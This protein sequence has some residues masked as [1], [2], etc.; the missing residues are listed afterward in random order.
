MALRAVFIG[1]NQYNDQG[2]SELNGAKRDALALW[3]LFTDSIEGLTSKLLVDQDATNS[4]VRKYVFGAL[5]E[6]NGDDVII[7]SFAGHGS[8][9]GNIILYDTEIGNLPGTAISMAS[10]AE[11]FK[12]TKA[13]TVLF[14]LDCCFS[15]QTPARVLETAGLPRSSFI[16]NEVYGEG[17]IILSACSVSES[18]WEQPG[19][20][21]GLLTYAIITALTDSDKQIVN[22]PDVVGEIIRLTRIEA[23]RINVK[24]T[25]MFLGT[26]IGGLTFPVLKRGANYFAA[27]PHK[28]TKK[29]SG[30]IEDLHQYG[31][32]PSI[33]DQWK[34]RFPHGLNSLQIQSI[35]EFGILAGNSL[36]VVA[37]TS[38]GKTLIGELAAIPSITLGKKVAFLLPYRALV[39]EKYE[40]FT[41]NYSLSGLRVVRCSG[42]STDGVAPVIKG[43]Y[44]LGFFT[45]ETFLNII[46]GSPG[47][48][49]Q[50]GLIVL[51]EGQFI[52]D[53]N[54]GIIVE[55]IFSFLLRARANGIEPQILVLSAVMGNINNF[56]RWLNLPLLISKERPV[57]LIEGVLDRRGQFQFVDVDATIKNEELLPVQSIVQRRDRPSSQDVIVPLSKKLVSNGEKLLIFR[58]QRGAAQGCA[59]YLANELGLEPAN[60]VLNTLP[61][62]DLTN[63]SQDL[64]LCLK[65]GVAFHNTNLLRSEREAVEKEF[66]KLNGEIHV[67]AATTT[68]AAGINTPA[69]TVILTE[70][71]FLGEDGREFTVAEY[72]NMAGRAGRVGF[73]EIGKSIILAETPLERA[74]LFQ[75]YVLGTP[76]EVQSSFQERDLSTW[77]IRLLSQVKEISQKEIPGLLINTFGGYSASLENPKWVVNIEFEVNTF[78]ERLL[79]LELAELEGDF[80]HLTL[81]GRAC[82]SSSLSF[83]SSMRLVEILKEIDTSKISPVHLLGILQ[84]LNE[85][86]SIYTPLMKRGQSES[87]R[88]SDA[89]KRYDLNVIQS[90][91]RYCHDQF[92]FW[93][94]CKRAS[95]L[96]DWI[97]GEHIEVIEKYY[98]ANPYQGTI[99]YGN[100]ASIAEGTRFHLRSAHK[101]LS[102]LLLDTPD[103]LS[104]LDIILQQLEFGLPRDALFLLKLEIP[105]T[106]GQYLA[107]FS[108]GCRKIEDIFDL[109]NEKFIEYVGTDIAKQLLSK[110]LKQ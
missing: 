59:K 12:T 22:F 8:P 70:N 23:E 95:I 71:E 27:F 29:V 14:I 24:Q 28:T 86:D 100:I 17:R 83:E 107:L 53:P 69:S 6:A 77:V 73:N 103:F 98:T 18:A 66:R 3:A 49:N 7:I 106:R 90:L 79:Q 67:I 13:K 102:T 38:S 109:S 85:L 80:I 26:V 20:G 32:P 105:L 60:Q 45:Y 89:S 41:F 40:D 31:F 4:E 76:E 16:L 61:T 48:L 1:I 65:G 75:K 72:K 21:H 91:K 84:V 62:Q 43:R 82:G 68:L 92:Q 51:D 46:L 64:H 33:I 10:L 63:A 56:D 50:L 35:N 110:P 74:Q 30:K 2:I 96:F 101:I 42:D 52:T 54:R 9:D 55:L 97:N 39:N 37:P 108:A 94:R 58:N 78:V 47:I 19:T 104:E 5:S 87:L 34:V 81:L 25:P 57:P 36:L 44:D 88:V 15:G 99:S 93:A 11:A